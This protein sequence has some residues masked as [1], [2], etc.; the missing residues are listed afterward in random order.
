MEQKSNPENDAAMATQCLEG[1]VENAANEIV[2]KEV[3]LEDGKK[4]S[5]EEAKEQ[6]KQTLRESL[7]SKKT[8]Q[9]NNAG[10]NLILKHLGE[11]PNDRLC[12]KELEGAANMLRKEMEKVLG[13]NFEKMNEMMEKNVDFRKL[14]EAISLEPKG[15]EEGLSASLAD[16]WGISSD[17]LATFYDIGTKLYQ[18]DQLEEAASVFTFMSSL[19]NYNHQVWLSLGLCHLRLQEWHQAVQAFTM[20]SVMIPE[21]PLPYLYT[22]DCYLA[23]NDMPN[24]KASLEMAEHFL[25]EENEE[26]IAPLIEHY[27]VLIQQHP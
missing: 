22:I 9:R 18:E 26:E 16:S 23:L 14:N 25:T 4:L 13:K 17:T 21:D 3:T 15:A 20:A 12:L 19:D 27:Q 10:F 1:A 24:A 2:W 7:D 5:P 8:A 6:F 11:Y